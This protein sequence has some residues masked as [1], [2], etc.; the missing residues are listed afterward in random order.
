MIGFN[1]L[2]YASLMSSMV[3][4]LVGNHDQATIFHKSDKT[5]LE[6][7]TKSLPRYLGSTRFYAS[8]RG[9]ESESR[10]SGDEACFTPLPPPLSPAALAPAGNRIG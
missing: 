8:L 6:S 3:E 10:E 7:C 2:S 1:T 4:A 5:F 9:P